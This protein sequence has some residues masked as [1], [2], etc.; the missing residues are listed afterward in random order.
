MKKTVFYVG[1][2]DQDARRQLVTTEAAAEEI[3]RI[4]FEHVGG[5]TISTA[6]GIYTH[7][8]GQR[9]TEETIIAEV[10]G[11]IKKA[12][13]VQLVRELKTAFNQE[14]IAVNVERVRGRFE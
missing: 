2:N 12:D 4:F 5:A 11:A 7:D 6:R 3:A 9:I 13:R 10:F 14:T 1:L 8:D